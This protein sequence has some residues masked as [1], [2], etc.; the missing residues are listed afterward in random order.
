[1]EKTKRRS[2]EESIAHLTKYLNDDLSEVVGAK[3]VSI[4]SANAEEAL[5]MGWELN[6]YHPI[7]ILEFDNGNALILSSDEEGNS[8]GFAFI[9]TR[10]G[11]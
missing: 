10:H 4:R 8:A 2:E 1:M 3:L 7:P 11:S 5:A 9:L 6:E